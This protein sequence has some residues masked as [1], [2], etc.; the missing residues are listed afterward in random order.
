MTST[1]QRRSRPGGGDP[2]SRGLILVGVAVVL[3]LIILIKGGGVGYEHSTKSVDV[4][5]N[6][7]ATTTSTAAPTTT[8]A[9]VAPADVPVV[10]ANGSGQT[11]LAKTVANNL[12]T[13][14]FTNTTPTDAVGTPPSTTVYFAPSFETSAQAIG[15]QLQLDASRV[16]AL[17]T[18]A[19][20]AKI[21]PDSV[22]VIV[23]LGQDASAATSSG[24]SSGGGS[25]TSTSTT[26][27]TTL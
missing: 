13:A 24:T 18:G 23:V 3:G 10:V 8:A 7:A 12:K 19:K 4:P 2:A 11:G 14:G 20:L 25:S 26:T 21:Q 5:D 15:T 17:P 6:G 22:G 1:Q 27:T 16:Q 9:T